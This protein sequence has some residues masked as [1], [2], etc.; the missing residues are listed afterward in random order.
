MTK[1]KEYDEAVGSWPELAVLLLEEKDEEVGEEFLAEGDV[2]EMEFDL[3]LAV[4]LAEEVGDPI[5]TTD[6]Y[7][8]ALVRYEWEDGSA[9]VLVWK[10]MDQ[11]PDEMRVE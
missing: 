10:G 8:S 2:D 6:E 5:R 9:V 1:A 3:T 4:M 11:D 7:G